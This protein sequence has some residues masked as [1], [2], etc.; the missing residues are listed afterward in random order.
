MATPR[1]HRLI[2]VADASRRLNT[3]IGARRRLQEEATRLNQNIA[4]EQSR[5]T[6]IDAEEEVLAAAIDEHGDTVA[7]ANA[8]PAT[9]RPETGA[10][11]ASP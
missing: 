4:V 6:E 2:G 3:A 10:G 11:G 1:T 9:E 5:L 7:E 8:E